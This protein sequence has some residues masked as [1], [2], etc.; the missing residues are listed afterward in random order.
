MPGAQ[1]W[2][3]LQGRKNTVAAL[4]AAKLSQSWHALNAM[5]AASSEQ[6]PANESR[7]FAME[8]ADIDLL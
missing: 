1:Q 4:N 3:C 7:L 6:F 5:P 8:S 2:T